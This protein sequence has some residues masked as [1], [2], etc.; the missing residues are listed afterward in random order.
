M[1]L[2]LPVRGSRK[3]KYKKEQ[4]RDGMQEGGHH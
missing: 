2:K 4:Q 1:S 3:E